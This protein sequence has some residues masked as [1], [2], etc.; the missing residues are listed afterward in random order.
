LLY[1]H[2]Y[3]L[4]PFIATSKQPKLATLLRNS[5]GEAATRHPVG[6]PVAA[7]PTEYQ[8]STTSFH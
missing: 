6:N 7:D 1:T 5:K 4:C 3:S 2:S 8:S